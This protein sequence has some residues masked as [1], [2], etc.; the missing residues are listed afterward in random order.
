MTLLEAN[1]TSKLLEY[2]EVRP[3]V[4]LI[5]P[6]PDTGFE[7]QPWLVRRDGRFVQVSELLYKLLERCDG[8]STPEQIATGLTTSSR[9]SVSPEN[10]TYLIREK[11]TPL[12]LVGLPEGSER[13][14]DDSAEDATEP[15]EPTSAARSSLAV[16]LRR[17]LLGPRAIDAVGGAFRF[18]FLP[19]I[20]VALLVGTLLAQG[21][22]FLGHGLE[23]GIAELLRR[24][25]AFLIVVAAVIL[26]A[27]FHEFG[28]AAG[29]RYGGGHP[30]GLGFGFYVIFPA[31]Y[32]D[33]TDAYR[34]PR[35]ARVRTDLG[36][37]YFHL[38]FSLLIVGAFLLT[39]QE[40]LLILV[41][42]IDVEVLRQFIPF[43]RLD[44]YWLLADLAGVPDFFSQAKPFLRGAVSGRGTGTKLP[45]TRRSVKVTFAVFLAVTFVILPAL[46]VVVLV[47][48]PHIAE[49]AWTALR[50]QGAA[51]RRA[52]E[53]GQVLDSVAGVVTMLLLLFQLAGLV[54]FVYLFAVRPILRAWTWT[55]HKPVPVRSMLRGSLAMVV[56]AAAAL[57]GTFYPWRKIGPMGGGDMAGLSTQ[58]G[59]LA[60]GCGLGLVAMAGLVLWVRRNGVRRLM[61]MSAVILGAAIA[62]VA[63]N[64]MLRIRG[65]VDH[66]IRQSISQTTGRDATSAQ[67]RDLRATATALGI[68]VSP[69]FGIQVTLAGGALAAAGGATALLVSSGVR[70]PRRTR[71]PRA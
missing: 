30:R 34:L 33:V 39:R 66:A 61:A 38:I 48:L 58:P 37:P 1:A 26:A 35:R 28:H 46:F 57:L 49:L 32:T 5:G 59:K 60:I 24:P 27:L 62:V 71:E 69:G 70:I 15:S 67:V 68:S 42:L 3:D 8:R 17:P 53:A 23:G 4:V 55:G 63:T 40:Y 45:P 54:A 64:D 22:L 2:P 25:A 44:G 29:L 20:V 41:M 12:G 21:W 19:P 43:L 52:W 13:A 65:A 14:E 18:L 9:W 16:N 7:Q 51:V 36:G 47:R 10:V 11:L 50:G 31:F 6:M 56:G